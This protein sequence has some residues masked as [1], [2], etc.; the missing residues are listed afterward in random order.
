MSSFVLAVDISRQGTKAAL[1]DKDLQQVAAEFEEANLLT[2][3]PGEAYQE[4]DD[5][6]GSVKRTIERVLSDTNAK[7]SDIAAIAVSGQ[8][9]GI[10][11][12]KPDG[13]AVTCYDSWLD[14]RCGRYADEMREKAGKKIT[15]ITG[16]PVL[17]THGPR[18]LW[19]MHQKPE[20]YKD[21][22]KFVTLYTYAVMQMCGLKADDAYLDY[23]CIQYSGFGDNKNKV[24]SDELL[25]MFDVSKDKLP[26]IVAPTDVVGKISKEFAD[27]TGL[28]EGT[29]VIAGMGG[30]AATL[31]GA[32]MTEPGQVHDFAGTANVLAG[33]LKEY[34]PDT[35]TET[36]VQMRSPIDGTWFPLVYIAGGGLALRWYRDTFTGTPPDEYEALEKEAA[37]V[38]VGSA[39]VMFFPMF[40]G[41]G[42]AHGQGVRACFTGLDWNDSRAHLYRAIMEGVAFEYCL[43]LCIMRNTYPDLAI[44]SL[45]ADEGAADS[46]LFNQIKADVLGMPV[47]TYELVDSAL[48]GDAALALVAAGDCDDPAKCVKPP[49]DAIGSFQPDAEK[50]KEYGSCCRAFCSMMDALKTVYRAQDVAES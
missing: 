12:V 41:Q 42:L 11:G 32:G 29:P 43:D 27:A 25:E 37:D 21:V 5:I 18:I 45:K 16:S 10:I 22:A 7:G 19:W 17:Y 1:Y 31:F 13:S 33:V 48:L 34:Q 28:A 6:M 3:A 24:W 15:E 47:E 38:P 39:G 23:T 8:M 44:S 26:K 46:P 14:T 40:S 49:T 4:P 36:F 50:S 20:V 2:P 9:G 30:T 35:Q